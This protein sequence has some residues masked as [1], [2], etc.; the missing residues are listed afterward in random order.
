[1]ANNENLIPGGHEFTLEEASRG[2]K[3]SAIA[4]KERKTIQN[5]LNE[6]LNT[7]A[8]DNPQ[9][10]KLAAKMGLKGEESIKDL[11]TIV[12]TLNT[13]KNANL[14]DLERLVKL[15]GETTETE[16]TTADKQAAFLDAVKKAVENG[17]K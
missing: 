12:C 9:V 7:T 1:M 13:L 14:S 4:R 2:G 8:K 10:A 5:I 11:F 3:N 16:S 6:Y 17:N 15:L